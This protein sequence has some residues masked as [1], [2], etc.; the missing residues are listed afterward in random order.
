MIFLHALQHGGVTRLVE[1]ERFAAKN[2]SPYFIRGYDIQ[3][4]V[5][6]PATF[7]RP[8]ATEVPYADDLDILDSVGP[9]NDIRIFAGQIDPADAS[10]FTIR[11]ESR[12]KTNI[13]DGYL[14]ADGTLRITVRQQP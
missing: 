14:Q 9:K 10:H 13:A 2:D 7:R 11:F 6:T 8:T 3:S 12:A 4:H 5:L 1:I